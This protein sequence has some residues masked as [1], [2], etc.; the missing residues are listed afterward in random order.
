RLRA[1]GSPCRTL[2]ESFRLRSRPT[3]SSTLPDV[4][5]HCSPLEPGAAYLSDPTVLIEVMSE[6]SKARDRFEKW[7][8][9]NCCRA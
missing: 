7:E 9:I 3:E 4:I 1:S 8:S 5:V 2:V 6:G